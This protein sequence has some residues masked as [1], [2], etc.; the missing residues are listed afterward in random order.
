[1]RHFEKR[2]EF[3]SITYAV[4]DAVDL[5]YLFS[6]DLGLLEASRLWLAVSGKPDKPQSRARLKALREA[7]SRL[8]EP[9][10]SKILRRL[11]RMGG[12]T[13]VNGLLIVSFATHGFSDG[14]AHQLAA[15][16]SVQGILADTGVGV[17]RVLRGLKQSKA[18]R[19]LLIVDACQ[20]LLVERSS[21]GSAGD[22]TAAFIEAFEQAKGLVSMVAAPEGALAFD[23]QRL[24]N[25]VFSAAILEGLRGAA[26][27]TSYGYI[28]PAT[29]LDYVESSVGAWYRERDLEDPGISSQAEGKLRSLP[30]A[31]CDPAVIERR[32]LCERRDLALTHYD[33]Y[34]TA[35]LRGEHGDR[36]RAELEGVELDAHHAELFAEIEKLDGTA[37]SSR[38]LLW[39]L[40]KR[41]REGVDGGEA[42]ALFYLGLVKKYGLGAQRV[43]L[44]E[45]H[46]HFEGAAERG[47]AV[48]K[49]WWASLVI[50]G[51]YGALA[52]SR[53]AVELLAEQLGPLERLAKAGDLEAIFVRGAV[54][55]NRLERPADFELVR[56]YFE[57]VR[58]LALKA[59]GQPRLLLSIA[60]LHLGWLA[61]QT[62]PDGPSHYLAMEH[63]TRSA[64]DGNAV[65]MRNLGQSF[66]RGWG[67]EQ[68]IEQAKIWY[69]KA[70][71]RGHSESMVRLG[72]AARRGSWGET[73]IAEA[74]DWFE[75]A[76][77]AGDNSGMYELGTT[78]LELEPANV[79]AGVEW[80]E[81]SM[82]H[83]NLWAMRYLGAIYADGQ[84]V[85]RD[86]D[87]TFSLWKRAAELGASDVMDSLAELSAQL[88]DL[89]RSHEWLRRGAEAGVVDC[90]VKYGLALGS[91]VVVPV[92]HSAAAEWFQRAAG[93][94]SS[95]GMSNLA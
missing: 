25:G 54:L 7:G 26:A 11:H 67:T 60:R 69:S 8:L 43:D 87:R 81:R 47:S 31:S 62:Q 35:P 9:T 50:Q 46:R 32:R 74:I 71:E 37:Q 93:A 88:G 13:T 28:T 79:P 45:A 51:S 92:D 17:P 18:E 38:A 77:A 39:W 89:P 80:L 19:K 16:D 82:A 34:L 95:W 40:E 33:E 14:T 72:Q 75:R 83:G 3:K 61:S 76:A 12:E 27:E 91:G 86:F 30:L 1:M 22:P 6:C 70:A 5:A 2:R 57:K 55:A 44:Q 41:W 52:D 58:D 49:A 23:D 85:P 68:N 94:G 84:I 4:D 73:S 20:E 63:F 56:G 42:R 53:R 21:R 10:R 29:L 66:E 36:I 90:M 59:T 64:A 15:Y 65:A 78:L 48:E 24:G